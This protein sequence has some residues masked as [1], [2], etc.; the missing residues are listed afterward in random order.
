MLDP[1]IRLEAEIGLYPL[2]PDL[3]PDLDAL[4]AALNS[5]ANP[6]RALLAT[7]YFGFPPRAELAASGRGM[8]NGKADIYKV[9]YDENYKAYTPAHC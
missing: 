2:T 3:A 4:E 6:V 7:H 9:A 5:C 8:A 1:V